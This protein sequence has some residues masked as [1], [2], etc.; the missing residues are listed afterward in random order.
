M[1][2]RSERRARCVRRIVGGDLCLS[3]GEDVGI[4]VTSK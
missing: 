1:G 3:E 2:M 4:G